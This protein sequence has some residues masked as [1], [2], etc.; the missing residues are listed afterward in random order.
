MDAKMTRDQIL[1]LP[2]M[3]YREDFGTFRA[4]RVIPTGDLHD[5][6]YKILALVPEYKDEP[7]HRTIYM[8][9]DAIHL[10]PTRDCWNVDVDSEGVIGIWANCSKGVRFKFPPMSSAYLEVV[11][12]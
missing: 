5:S 7:K 9:S 2:R 4:L 1:S 11:R 12:D 8:G 10:E 6:G 3:D